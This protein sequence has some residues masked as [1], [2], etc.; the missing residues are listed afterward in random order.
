MKMKMKS[1]IYLILFITFS[2]NNVISQNDT[3]NIDIDL[4]D[5]GNKIK[6]KPKDGTVITKSTNTYDFLKQ[7]VTIIKAGKKSHLGIT[8]NNKLWIS[9]EF[10]EIIEEL[11]EDY[12]VKFKGIDDDDSSR[13]TVNLNL[14]ENSKLSYINDIQNEKSIVLSDETDLESATLI[15]FY[16]NSD[17]S[18]FDEGVVKIESR[19]AN[20]TWEKGKGKL[21]TKIRTKGRRILGGMLIKKYMLSDYKDLNCKTSSKKKRR[22]SKKSNAKA[23]FPIGVFQY[24]NCGV[25]LKENENYVIRNIPNELKSTKEKK[26]KDEKV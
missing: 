14:Q 19:K 23:S 1:F 16:T 4:S 10:A 17:D 25:L 11:G 9:S 2:I 12:K 3:I 8:I 26:E 21:K 20:I 22:S 13:K 18:P 24:K 6:T 7:T 15:I 5:F